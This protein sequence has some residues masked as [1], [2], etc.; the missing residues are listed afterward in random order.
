MYLSGGKVKMYL[1]LCSQETSMKVVLVVV[2]LLI[3]RDL[4]APAFPIT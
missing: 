3:K 2:T 4:K 1:F